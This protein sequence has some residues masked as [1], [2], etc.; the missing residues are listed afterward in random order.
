LPKIH[1]P[2]VILRPTV[3]TIGSPTYRLAKRLAV[4]LSTYTCD[5]PH[6]VRNSAEFVHTLS[7]YS[8]HVQQ[9]NDVF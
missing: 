7:S 3:S 1:K 6:H 2:D 8:F 5:S 9:S 4:L